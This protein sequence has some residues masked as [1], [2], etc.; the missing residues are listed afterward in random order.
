MLLAAVWRLPAAPWLP[1]YPSPAH[2]LHH[3]IPP[4]EEE[5]KRLPAAVFR[6]KFP[7]L[8]AEQ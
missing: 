3:S 6:C 1:K 2:P 7:S 4:A 5:A 8:A